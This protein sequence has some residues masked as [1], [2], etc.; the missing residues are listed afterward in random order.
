MFASSH[1]EVFGSSHEELAAEPGQ[2]PGQGS[3]VNKLETRFQNQNR[4]RG[5][6]Y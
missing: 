2:E 1:E 4:G 3:K 6:A 5:Q